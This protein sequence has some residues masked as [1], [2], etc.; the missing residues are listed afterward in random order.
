MLFCTWGEDH[1]GLPACTNESMS[2]SKTRCAPWGTPGLDSC[3]GLMRTMYPSY[4]ASSRA[5]RSGSVGSYCSRTQDA[6]ALMTPLHMPME[7]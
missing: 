7:S 1:T 5:M 4:C 2:S 6:P 3:P